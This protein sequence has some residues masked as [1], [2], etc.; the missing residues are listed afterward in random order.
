MQNIDG[1]CNLMQTIPYR[2]EINLHILIRINMN[3]DVDDFNW[4]TLNLIKCI[5]LVW[6]FSIKIQI[7][8]FAYDYV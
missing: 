2:H 7:C 4:L 5:L 6:L 3:F 1:V 8:D